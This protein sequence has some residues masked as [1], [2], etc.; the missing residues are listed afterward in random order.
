MR[1]AAACSPLRSTW[2]CLVLVLSLVLVPYDQTDPPEAPAPQRAAA[3]PLCRLS[4][5]PQRL[6]QQ[7]SPGVFLRAGPQPLP[8]LFQGQTRT[9]AGPVLPGPAPRGPQSAV[10]QRRHEPGQSGP[11]PGQTRTRT[12]TRPCSALVNDSETC[13]VN[14][15]VSNDTGVYNNKRRRRTVITII[16]III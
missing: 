11:G 2:S 9:H 15:D 1:S 14:K 7:L 10:R 4:A 13:Q 5:L 12:G 16:I 6:R 3:P 8:G